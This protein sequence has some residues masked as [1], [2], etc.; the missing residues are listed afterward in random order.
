MEDSGMLYI[1]N[2]VHLF[3]LHY[4]FKARVNDALKQFVQARNSHPISGECNRSPNQLV[5][6]QSLEISTLL[7]QK[8]IKLRDNMLMTWM[9]RKNTEL[10]PVDAR[11]LDM[12][13]TQESD[14]GVPTNAVSEIGIPLDVALAVIDPLVN[15][16]EYGL[17]LYQREVEIIS[18]LIWWF[19]CS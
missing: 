14:S 10:R 6:S 17:Q 11:A 3:C 8:R 7:S 5:I 19:C 18:Q 4:I 2:Q 15:D 1:N 12:L 13:D 16:G 9:M